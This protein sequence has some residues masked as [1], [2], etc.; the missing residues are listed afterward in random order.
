MSSNEHK[1]WEE[2]FVNLARKYER[3]HNKFYE[4]DFFE[5]EIADECVAD[6]RKFQNGLCVFNNRL[7]MAYSVTEIVEVL[8]TMTKAIHEFESMKEGKYEV[9]DN[10]YVKYIREAILTEEEHEVA[11]TSVYQLCGLI[12]TLVDENQ[13][14]KQENKELKKGDSDD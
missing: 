3:L 8:N 9:V 11:I 10:G 12:N 14:L 1:D 7:G 4:R 13:K 6:S 5:V 2:E